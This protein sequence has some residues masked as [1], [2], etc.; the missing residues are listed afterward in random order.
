MPIEKKKSSE[1]YERLQALCRENGTTPTS[2][3]VDVTGSQG[4]LATW[5]K[6]NIRTDYLLQI[7]NRFDVSID[8]LLG[9]TDVPEVNRGDSMPLAA[10]GEIA[11]FGGKTTRPAVVEDEPETTAKKSR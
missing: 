5:K 2:L 7:A 6:G 8:Y 9:R 11:A 4:N 3:C 10:Y 1:I